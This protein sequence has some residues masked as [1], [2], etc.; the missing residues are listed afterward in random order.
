MSFALL[1]LV[2]LIF[3]TPIT[4]VF[5][6]L[7]VQGFVAAFAA[8]LLAIVALRI[9]PGEARFLSSVIRPVA[10]VAAVPAIWMLIQLLP[11]QHVGLAHPIWKSTAAALGQPVVESI[12][13]DPGATLISFVRYVSAAAIAFVAAAVATDRRRAEW[14]LLALTG[15]T[16]LMALIAL[17]LKTGIF[18]F[19]GATDREHASITAVDGASLGIIFATAAVLLS[20]ERGKAQRPHQ[21]KATTLIWP[22]FTACLIAL[23]TCFVAVVNQATS[24]NYYAVFCGLSTFAIAM[25]IRRFSL[26][27]WGIAAII[28]ITLFSAIA[29]VALQPGGRILDLTVNFAT[30]APTPLVAVTRRVLA[31]MSWAGN[32]A[33]TFAAILP[34]YQ[35]IDELAI[36]HVA[37]TAAAAIAIEMGWPIFW[38]ILISAIALALLLLR[39]ALRRQRDSYYSMAGAGCV[40]AAA[41]LS[42]GSFALLTTPI[43][44]IIAVAIGIA[45]AQS[46][47]RLS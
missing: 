26:G 30:Q 20:S 43:S 2:L 1:I 37:P 42:F 22:L 18:T 32:G 6:G 45:I 47:S 36:G 10:V 13:I 24:Q 8:V 12:T 21:D 19:L 23:G 14:A 7:V 25:M 4:I 38:A 33:G 15:A 46:K 34:I 3:A 40:V 29:I 44:I 35:G 5:D 27:P 9:R 28:S 11:M 31:E 16:T 41:L 17:A 39:G